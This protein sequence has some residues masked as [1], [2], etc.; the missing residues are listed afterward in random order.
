[1]AF[2]CTP[3][4]VGRGAQWAGESFAKLG[5]TRCE[6]IAYDAAGPN[7]RVLERD[8]EHFD[9]GEEQAD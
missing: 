6:S 3:A 4:V 5:R 1:M 8:L 9:G 7:H 2:D